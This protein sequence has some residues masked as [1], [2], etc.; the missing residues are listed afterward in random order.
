MSNDLN[1]CSF[2]GRLGRDPET[3]YLPSGKAVTHFS[4]AVGSSWK[5]KQ[6]GEKKEQ[7]EWVN[8][9]AFEK[10]GEICAQYLK[11]GS[12]VFIQGAFKTRKWQDKEGKDRYSTEIIANQ[13]QML[14]GKRE[15]AEPQ[16]EEKAAKVESQSSNDDYSDEI[17]FIWLITALFTGLLSAVSFVSSSGYMA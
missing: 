15:G 6:T 9:V 17:P 5:D 14:G 16:R 1:S 2:I 12:Q 10:L 8:I 7:T 3:R 13:L 11:K 4:I